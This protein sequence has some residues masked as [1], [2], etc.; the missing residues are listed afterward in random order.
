V[1]DRKYLLARGGLNLVTDEELADPARLVQ[2][3]AGD[4]V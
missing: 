3:F 4:I 1:A 2:L